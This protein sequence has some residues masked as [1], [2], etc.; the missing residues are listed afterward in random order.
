MA[1]ITEYR[2]KFVQIQADAKTP[3]ILLFNDRVAPE[4]QVS[5]DHQRGEILRC[6]YIMR[7]VFLS[8]GNHIIEFRFKPSL[9]T[10]YVT[11][12]AI[13][14]GIAVA[15]YLIATRPPSVAP[16]ENPLPPRPPA[17]APAAAPLPAQAVKPVAA[18]AAPP[19]RSGK[20]K[21]R[22]V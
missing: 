3:S 1:T 21:A 13:V 15:G 10:L 14:V 6:N 12:C 8:P 22:K 19:R 17:P 9:K 11:L 7:G 5:I 4:W 16:A 20:K 2:P 18:S